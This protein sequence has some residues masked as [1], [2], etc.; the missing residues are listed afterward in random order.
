MRR[1]WI[2]PR[3][4][5][6]LLNVHHPSFSVGINTKSIKPSERHRNRGQA[7]RSFVFCSSARRK[8]QLRSDAQTLAR[9]EGHDRN[10]ARGY[11]GKCKQIQVFGLT[12][13]LPFS[14]SSR[15]ESSGPL[16]GAGTGLWPSIFV[17]FVDERTCLSPGFWQLPAKGGSIV[18]LYF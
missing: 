1:K 7:T 11:L 8:H 9:R 3:G 4:I 6:F 17:L 16:Q 2:K 5:V 13:R 12:M 18:N 10:F 15:G 14:L